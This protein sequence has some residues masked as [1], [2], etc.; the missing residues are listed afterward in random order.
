MRQY[1]K[2]L[3]DGKI[4]AKEIATEI[5]EVVEVRELPKEV[6][7]SLDDAILALKHVVMQCNDIA[8]NTVEN[9]LSVA[10]DKAKAM[11]VFAAEEMEKSQKD[12]GAAYDEIEQLK[13]EC[14][15]E[16]CLLN[17]KITT[18]NEENSDL[19]IESNSFKKAHE[20]TQNNNRNLSK[21][22]EIK[23]EQ[24]LH[25][26]QEC[27]VQQTRS[28]EV[29]KQLAEAQKSNAELIKKLEGAVVKHT[30][31]TVEI[32]KLTTQLTDVTKVQKEAKIDAK[33]Q[34]E[35]AN[36]ALLDVAK[37]QAETVSAKE[38]ITALKDSDAMLHKQLKSLSAT[39]AVEVEKAKVQIERFK[40]K[41]KTMHN[42][43]RSDN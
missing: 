32:A 34:T 25:A 37:S 13:D 39:H 2:L 20:D 7:E 29:A 42:Q 5:T 1:N 11:E 23:T 6:G 43:S 16:T 36:N 33:L 22:L 14:L 19:K 9:R 31:D 17:E 8:H 28:E 21:K 30:S 12:L 3:E 10:I 4:I 35:I 27:L 24:C 26:V 15:A 41:I 18:L 38:Q 40:D